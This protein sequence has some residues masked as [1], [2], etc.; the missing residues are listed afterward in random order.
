MNDIVKPEQNFRQIRLQPRGTGAA[1]VPQTVGEVV[2]LAEMMSRAGQAVPKH[3]RGEPGICFAIASRALVWEMDPFAVATKTYV[4]N[5]AVAYEAQLV[6]SLVHTRAPIIG[7]PRYTFLGSGDGLQCKIIWK[8]EADSDPMEYLSPTLGSISPKN[9]PLWK[10]HPEQQLGYHSIRAMARRY[11]PEL[12]LGVYTP[13]EMPSVQAERSHY[14]KSFDQME[15]A[16]RVKF[17][18]DPVIIEKEAAAIVEKVQ[19]LKAEPVDA[20]EVKTT[21]TI[22]GFVSFARVISSAKDWNM[23]IKPAL[24]ALQKLDD[25]KEAGEIARKGAYRAAFARLSDLNKGEGKGADPLTDVVAYRC[26]IEWEDQ[27]DTLKW[28]RNEFCSPQNPSWASLTSSTKSA[29]DN[30][31]A[32]R[33]EF[34][35]AEPPVDDATYAEVI[36]EL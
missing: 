21:E 19:A 15:Q 6:A 2:T 14:A 3:C 12:L 10:T 17:V 24:K 22:D 34:L 31:M 18:P 8:D 20:Q 27:V 29:L 4:V 23:E 7:R 36:D 25:W 30:A 16:A 11:Y 33:L 13:D 28:Y 5:D 9:S 35:A 1:L 26:M 32:V